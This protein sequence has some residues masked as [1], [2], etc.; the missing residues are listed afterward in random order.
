[1]AFLL[2]QFQGL[3]SL[4]IAGLAESWH[5]TNSEPACATLNWPA[6]LPTWHRMGQKHIKRMWD[7]NSLAACSRTGLQRQFGTLNIFK[8]LLTSGDVPALV[9][10]YQTV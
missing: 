10:V 5:G 2:H 6:E 7:P 4:Q 9:F 3:D 1:M 8:C